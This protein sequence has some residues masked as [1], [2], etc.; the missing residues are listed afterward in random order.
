MLKLHGE[1][2]VNHW[3]FTLYKIDPTDFL[4]AQEEEMELEKSGCPYPLPESV[5]H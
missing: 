4:V 2:S 1:L 5:F 3:T